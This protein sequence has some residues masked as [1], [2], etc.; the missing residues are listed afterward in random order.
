LSCTAA[1][2]AGLEELKALMPFQGALEVAVPVLLEHS[3]LVPSALQWLLRLTLEERVGLRAL[4]VRRAACLLLAR[5]FWLAEEAL[6]A[7]A[8]RISP[9]AAEAETPATARTEAEILAVK[10]AARVVLNSMKAR[11]VLVG[12]GVAA[13]RAIRDPILLSLAVVAAARVIHPERHQF[14]VGAGV[15]Q[16][17]RHPADRQMVRPEARAVFIPLG[18]VVGAVVRE[19]QAVPVL[20]LRVPTVLDWLAEQAVAVA[21]ARTAE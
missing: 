13:A 17:A 1:V 5:R 18:L 20:E 12:E 16:V 7:R 21:R 2:A 19:A 15:V 9:A 8:A 14:T 6:E 4:Q 10:V 11:A 3:R